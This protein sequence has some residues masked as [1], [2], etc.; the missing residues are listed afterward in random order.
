MSTDVEKFCFPVIL[1]AGPADGKELVCEELERPILMRVVT[2]GEIREVHCY[3]FANRSERGRW[4][5][6]WKRALGT[7][8]MKGGA[9]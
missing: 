6:R 5:F 1:Y 8:G 3:E 4:V 2:A 7:Q 9:K